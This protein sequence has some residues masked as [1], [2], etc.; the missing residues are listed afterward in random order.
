[1]HQWEHRHFPV[2]FTGRSKKKRGIEK[3]LSSR[4][5]EPVQFGRS[6]YLPELMEGI[7]ISGKRELKDYFRGLFRLTDD[8][9]RGRDSSLHHNHMLAMINRLSCLPCAN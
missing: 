8:R 1:M 9:L 7:V 2:T 6:D 3:A 5:R 4:E